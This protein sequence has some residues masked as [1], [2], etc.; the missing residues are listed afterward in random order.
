MKVGDIVLPDFPEHR[1]DW[2]QG[3]PDDLPGVILEVTPYDTFIVMTPLRAE[4]VNIEYLV[5]LV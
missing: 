2:R 3:W 4:E 1:N 5:E